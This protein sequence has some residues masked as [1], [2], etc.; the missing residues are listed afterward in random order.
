MAT[1]GICPVCGTRQETLQTLALEHL[2]NHLFLL[3]GSEHPRQ[4]EL[5]LTTLLSQLAENL[6][7]QQS[8]ESK[9][10]TL[11]AR[12]ELIRRQE[13]RFQFEVSKARYTQPVLTLMERD[14]PPTSGEDL[15]QT[16]AELIK[17]ERDLFAQINQRQRDLE[18][19]YKRF[20][21][22]VE[23]RISQLRK[24]YEA[25]ATDFLGIQCELEE[26]QTSDLFKFTRFIPRFNSIDRETPDSC[27]EA[28][29]FFLD[30]AYRMALIDSSSKDN[31]G[32]AIFICETPE[33]ALDISYI[34]NVVQMFAGFSDRG[35]SLLLTANI[36]STSIA[37]ELLKSYPKSERQNRIL[38]LLDFGQLS[39]VH[40]NAIKMLKGEVRKIMR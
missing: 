21:D 28:Q 8:L 32:S 18:R 27:S 1:N 15:K 20:R 35:H 13:D 6:R 34:N 14:L 36:Q 11:Q 5:E 29:R 33:S 9:C 38:N 10:R 24:A 7:S 39:E 40:K 16:K 3:F 37:G 17:L 12:F 26:V 23:N 19:D 30:I 4:T 22:A 25:Y 2:N 31:N